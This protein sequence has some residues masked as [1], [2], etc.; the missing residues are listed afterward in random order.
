M[1]R[2]SVVLW[3]GLGLWLAFP[4]RC[5]APLIFTPGEGW[6]YESPGGPSGWQKGRA[7]D[8]I[9]IAEEAFAKQDYGLVLKATKRLVSQ[10][11]LADAAPRAYYLM[12]RAYEEKGKD[13]KAFKTYQKLIERHPN[14]DNYDEI[15]ERQF[16]IANRFLAGQWFKLFGVV[17]FFPSMAKTIEMYEQIVKNGPY[18]PVAPQ[19][20]MNIGAANENKLLKDYPDA[21]KAYQR[22]A[23]RYSDQPLGV[24][25]LYK[26]AETYGKQAKTA[27]YD[28]SVA[29]EAIATYS[30]FVAL[31][32]ADER[33]STAQEQVR[34]LRTEQARGSYDI[35]QFY[36]K[37][38]RW[39][40]ALVYYNE[41]IDKDQT[42]SYAGLARRR[43]ELINR[44]IKLL[45][46]GP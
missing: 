4:E 32:P 44:Y 43:I 1:K 23:D 42:S 16:K 36:E 2:R 40:G 45:P 25:A 38:R 35:A 3:L 26:L 29:S 14:L 13:E 12:G 10:W 39:K 17:P 6:H 18:S 11:P 7:E 5:P 28:Q 8:Q 30:D 21:A 15:L 37:R 24:D 46:E 9:K 31:H 34:I 33:V 27:E 41:V 19:A 20:Q 22:A